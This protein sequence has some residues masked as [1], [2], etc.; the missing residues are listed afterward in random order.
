MTQILTGYEQ[1]S[2][3]AS[4]I[5]V[6]PYCSY[7]SSGFVI[8]LVY[9]IF[10]LLMSFGKHWLISLQITHFPAVAYSWFV[11]YYKFIKNQEQFYSNRICCR[12]RSQPRSLSLS[13]WLWLTTPA[14]VTAKPGPRSLQLPVSRCYLSCFCISFH[15]HLSPDWVFSDLCCWANMVKTTYCRS[16][17]KGRILSC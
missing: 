3:N 5:Q 7:D 16:T 2:A 10:W 11:Y 1:W 8:R 14:A 13:L 12:S 9:N 6:T 15:G 4:R 17:F